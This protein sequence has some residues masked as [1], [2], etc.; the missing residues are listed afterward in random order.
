MVYHV[1]TL[2]SDTPAKNPPLY[3]CLSLVSPSPHRVIF[4]VRFLFCVWPWEAPETMVDVFSRP[5]QQLGGWRLFDWK[6]L[7]LFTLIALN[8]LLSYRQLLVI[9]QTAPL[10]DGPT[11]SYQVGNSDLA[12][13][14]PRIAVMS[15]FVPNTAEY[16]QP[17]LKEEYFPHLINK[18]CYS[19]IWGYDFIFNTTYGFDGYP[20][21]HWLEF[22]TWHRLPHV[23]SRLHEY[24]WILYSKSLNSA[25]PSVS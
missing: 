10:D 14:R 23:K 19:Y 4:S 15:S 1:H 22:G 3:L 8:I 25:S 21:W 9:M 12:K 11:P 24:D 7:I 17:R 2:S 16:P 18:A 13:K 6:L 20:K 5:A